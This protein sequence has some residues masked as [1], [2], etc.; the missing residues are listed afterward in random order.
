V[1]QPP[2]QFKTDFAPGTHRAKTIV[3]DQ[4]SKLTGKPLSLDIMDATFD[5]MTVTSDLDTAA[6]VDFANLAHDM[7]VF[8]VE[9]DIG[10]LFKLAK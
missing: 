5:R 7:G 4:I 1:S 9:P 2:T 8:K 3:N 10:G 6:V